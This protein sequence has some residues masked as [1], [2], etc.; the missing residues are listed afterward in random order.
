MDDIRKM[1]YADLINKL[2]QPGSYW[3]PDGSQQM[4]D[5]KIA[6][7]QYFVVMFNKSGDATPVDRFLTRD[8]LRQMMRKMD[9][10]P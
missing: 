8:E 7:D 4:W 6:E 10:H 5:W 2:G 3:T 9:A 1:T